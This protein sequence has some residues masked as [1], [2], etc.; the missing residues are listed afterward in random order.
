[1]EV[2]TKVRWL[3][4]ENGSQRGGLEG[5]VHLHTNTYMQTYVI[6]TQE[7]N[8]LS[9]IIL[10]LEA[11]SIRAHSCITYH[12]CDGINRKAF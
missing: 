2:S 6:C 11:K 3:R 1:M 9:R 12:V 4:A 10:H 5:A 7:F 8:V